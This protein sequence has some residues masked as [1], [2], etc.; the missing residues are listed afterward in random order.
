MAAFV[1][2][3][4]MAVGSLASAGAQA[5]SERFNAAAAITDSRNAANIAAS[6]EEVFRGNARQEIAKQRAWIAQ[7]GG[8][9]SNADVLEQS[10]LNVERDALAIR[11][12]GQLKVQR[13][14][15]E[16]ELSKDRARAANVSGAINAA[17]SVIGSQSRM[18]TGVSIGG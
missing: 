8:G 6:E 17:S 5:R 14:L 16:A 15:T 4:F 1:P 2:M 10:I 11:Y 12:G 3:I 9:G 18:Q 7:I 13:Y